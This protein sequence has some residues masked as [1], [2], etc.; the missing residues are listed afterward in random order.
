MSGAPILPI[1]LLMRKGNQAAMSTYSYMEGSKHQIV[2]I[3][4]NIIFWG[5]KSLHLNEIIPSDL[6]YKPSFFFFQKKSKFSYI[7]LSKYLNISHFDN[8]F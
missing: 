8:T 1:V 2:Y 3:M 5:K 6:L 7:S 4:Q